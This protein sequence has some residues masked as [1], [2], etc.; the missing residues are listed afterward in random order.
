MGEVQL[1]HGAAQFLQSG[2]QILLCLFQ[3][4][5]AG[6]HLA[7]LG[8]Q[9]LLEGAVVG[10]HNGGRGK[11]GHG[12]VVVLVHGVNQRLLVNGVGQGQAQVLVGHELVLGVDNQVVRGAGGLYAN[13][14]AGSLCL[15]HNLRPLSRSV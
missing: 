13:F 3:I 12:L 9:G 7:A 10:A 15:L 8:H 6:V 4:A 1:I 5:A 11:A 2:L 14:K